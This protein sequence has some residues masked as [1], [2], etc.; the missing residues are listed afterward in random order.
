MVSTENYPIVRGEYNLDKEKLIRYIQ[1]FRKHN[2]SYSLVERKILFSEHTYGDGLKIKVQWLIQKPEDFQAQE[3]SGVNQLIKWS[4]EGVIECSFARILSHSKNR[5]EVE[6]TI[7]NLFVEEV[8][9]KSIKKLT[10]SEYKKLEYKTKE[11]TSIPDEE[12]D[13]L[14]EMISNYIL[15]EEYCK[16]RDQNTTK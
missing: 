11:K 1:A 5:E 6:N 2:I 3:L 12:F 9:K 8:L 14:Q 4:E 7:R 10:S 16:K 15:F 13:K